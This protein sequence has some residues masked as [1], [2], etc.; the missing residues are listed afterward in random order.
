MLKRMKILKCDIWLSSPFPLAP[1]TEKLGSVKIEQEKTQVWAKKSELWVR[2]WAVTV[3]YSHVREIL[4]R[5][6]EDFFDSL[7]C[8]RKLGQDVKGIR[9]KSDE[10]LPANYIQLTNID[11]TSLVLF[12]KF[13]M[14]DIARFMRLLLKPSERCS[15]KFKN[16]TIFKKTILNF[17]G[18]KLE[19]L[20]QIIEDAYDT[21][22][23]EIDIIRNKPIVH[24]RRVPLNLCLEGNEIGVRLQYRANNKT[25]EK[26]ISN[27]QVDYLCNHAY[28]F[29]IDL[30]E[31]L[32]SNFEHLPLEISEKISER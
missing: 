21:W 16:F 26:F 6:D 18:N 5:I 25:E 17:E 1:F 15:P 12:I 19:K 3:D 27:L 9:V 24:F 4:R 30:N 29:L 22:F 8:L 11:V 13:L 10:L 28:R 20:K 7:E 32:C 31:Y 23:E 2:L 14:D